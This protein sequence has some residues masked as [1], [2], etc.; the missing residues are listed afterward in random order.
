MPVNPKLY[1]QF[2]SSL[3]ELT[4]LK[5]GEKY[6]DPFDSLIY[7]MLGIDEIDETNQINYT[8]NKSGSIHYSITI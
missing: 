3:V 4:E 7:V 5:V 6:Y 8:I 1:K 2:N